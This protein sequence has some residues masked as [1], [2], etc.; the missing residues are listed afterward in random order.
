MSLIVQAN[1]FFQKNQI[2]QAEQLYRQLLKV[3]PNDI[4]RISNEIE[5]KLGEEALH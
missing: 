3:N 4:A 1:L 5:I 2:K